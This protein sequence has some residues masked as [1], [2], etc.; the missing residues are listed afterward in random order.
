MGM[1]RIKKIVH[2]LMSFSHPDEGKQ[3]DADVHDLIQSALNIAW[4][5]IKHKAEVA[6]EYGN[7]PRIS[8]YPQ[9]LSQVFLNIFVNAVQAI[10]ENGKI[11]IRTSVDGDK[12]V[13]EISDNGR[14]MPEEVRKHI[15]EPFYTTKPI[16]KGTGLRVVHGI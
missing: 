13:I 4:N 9:Q 16:G 6:K 1:L 8:C 3:E 12:I 11:I 2:D 14:G 7:I 15:F 5:E 10:S